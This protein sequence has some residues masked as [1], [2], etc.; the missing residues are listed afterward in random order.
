MTTQDVV[1]GHREKTLKLLWALILHYQVSVLLH[2]DQLREE[3]L[4]LEKS[5]SVRTKLHKLGLVMAG[6][7]LP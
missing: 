3:V 2:M 5:L 7:S 6:R 1:E 4:V